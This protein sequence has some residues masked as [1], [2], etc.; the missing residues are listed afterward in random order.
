M[1]RH[2]LQILFKYRPHLRPHPLTSCSVILIIS[3]ASMNCSS[4]YL[5]AISTSACL[6]DGVIPCCTT[7]TAR[8]MFSSCILP[9]YLRKKRRKMIEKT[10]KLHIKEGDLKSKNEVIPPLLFNG[11]YTNFNIFR[12]EYKHLIGWIIVMSHQYREVVP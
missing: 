12:K 2:Q 7:I 11:L 4:I 1:L 8:D 6:A 5:G 10:L 9:T 3:S